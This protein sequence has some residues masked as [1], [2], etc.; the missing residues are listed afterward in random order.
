MLCSNKPLNRKS[1]PALALAAAAMLA[2][3]AGIAADEPKSA[4]TPSPTPTP[5]ASASNVEALKELPKG[6]PIYGLRIP[7]MRDG[8]QMSLFLIE[9]ARPLD[10]H[11]IEMENLEIEMLNDDGT[12]FHVK[13]PKSVFDLDTGILTSD[14]PTQI[15]R[16]DFVITGDAAEFHTKTRFGRMTGK[17][18]MIIQT[19]NVE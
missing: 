6:Q 9:V 5:A 10:D 17:V 3:S 18:K 16:E 2:I 12:T 19:E 13:T 7:E 4:P 11:R 15:R 8:K 14:T 1:P